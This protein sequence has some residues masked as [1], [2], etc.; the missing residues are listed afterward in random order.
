MNED[1]SLQGRVAI[2]TGSARNIGRAIARAL[3]DAGAAVVINAKSSAADADAVVREIRDRGGQA[4][5]KIADVGQPEAAAS[6]IDAAIAAFG[7][8]DILVNNAAVRREIDFER[9]DYDEWRAITATILDG[10]PAT[11]LQGGHR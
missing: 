7:R 11:R 9:L 8:L 3:A 6:L 1:R 10:A 2:V 5:A 4:V